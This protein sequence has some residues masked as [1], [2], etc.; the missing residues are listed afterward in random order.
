MI[1]NNIYHII[2]SHGR[3]YCYNNKTKI[4]KKKRFISCKYFYNLT[5]LFTL[6]LAL[7]H[8]QSESKALYKFGIFQENLFVAKALY[9]LIN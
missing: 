9:L 1:I 2:T 3:S 7:H 6:A 4:K 8:S 5:N